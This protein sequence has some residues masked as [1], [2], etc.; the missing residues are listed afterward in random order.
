MTMTKFSTARAIAIRS[1]GHSNC[2]N[3]IQDRTIL[4]ASLES[5]F[6]CR[7][8]SGASSI[9]TT[10]NVKLLV[11]TRPCYSSRQFVKLRLLVFTTHTFS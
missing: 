9:N 1:D 2:T 3:T 4:P 7:S 6:A 10:F 8:L 5:I 11:H